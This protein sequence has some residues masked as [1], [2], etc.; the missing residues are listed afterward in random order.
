MVLGHTAGSVK[1]IS[2]SLRRVILMWG[3]MI[4]ELWEYPFLFELNQF[5]ILA[6]QLLT[7]RPNT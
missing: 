5:S 3:L 6:T 1:R 7:Q 4:M 2:P